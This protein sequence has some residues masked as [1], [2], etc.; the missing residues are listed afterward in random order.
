MELCRA[1]LVA[2]LAAT[3]VAALAFDVQLPVVLEGRSYTLPVSVE[4]VAA[5][6]SEVRLNVDLT[7]IAAD[8][9]VLAQKGLDL[10]NDR[11]SLETSVSGVSLSPVDGGTRVDLTIPWKLNYCVFG[12]R[13][14]A[15]SDHSRLSATLIV[16]MKDRTQV[17]IRA[18]DVDLSGEIGKLGKSEINRRVRAAVERAVPAY[19][20]ARVVPAPLQGFLGAIELNDISLHGGKSDWRLCAKLLVN[21]PVGTP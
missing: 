6:P 11:C 12:H 13:N 8:A 10:P 21:A 5:A 15:V 2:A 4:L 20:V 16:E 7:S 14:K 17:L 1:V 9:L 3:P 19:D 18:K